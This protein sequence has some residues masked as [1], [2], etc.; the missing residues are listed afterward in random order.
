M[1]RFILPLVLLGA[2][3]L[4]SVGAAQSLNHTLDKVELSRTPIEIAL[5]KIFQ[6][7][8]SFIL[9]P[10]VNGDI[11]ASFNRISAEKALAAVLRSAKATYRFED[12]IYYIEPAV[13]IALPFS[14]PLSMTFKDVEVRTAIKNVMKASRATY[15]IAPDVKGTVTLSLTGE[16]FTEALDKILEQVGATYSMEGGVVNIKAK[17]REHAGTGNETRVSLDVTSAD[18][19]S[20]LRLM[21]MGKPISM[22]ID[23]EVDGKVTAKFDSIR[24]E[25]ALEKLLKQVGATYRSDGG[26]YQIVPLKK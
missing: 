2:A 26:V 20:A 5:R 19:S 18:L 24:L 15:T 8:V 21:L 3:S 25:D 23:S 1:R 16:G 11:T 7:K 14:T 17:E 4:S 10:E 9:S 6:D 22:V 13:E 12:G